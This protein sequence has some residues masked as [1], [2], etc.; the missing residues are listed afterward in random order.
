MSK[1]TRNYIRGLGRDGKQDLLTRV[2]RDNRATGL[3]NHRQA[4][5]V[6]KVALR[7]GETDGLTSGKRR[8]YGDRYE[9]YE[10]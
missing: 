5:R 8:R 4:R 2:V 6:A 10:L 7:S 1:T 3:R 9:S